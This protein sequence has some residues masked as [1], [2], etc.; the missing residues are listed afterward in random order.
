M[1]TVPGAARGDKNRSKGAIRHEV[2][3]ECSAIPTAVAQVLS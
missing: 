1:K 3:D 2:E